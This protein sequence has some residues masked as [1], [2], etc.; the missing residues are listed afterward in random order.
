MVQRWEKN[1]CEIFTSTLPSITSETVN[2]TEYM[3]GKPSV[4]AKLAKQMPLATLMLEGE[5]K[6]A[7]SLQSFYGW[8]AEF[9]CHIC[10]PL[11][12]SP[13]PAV[14][15]ILTLVSVQRVP[16]AIAARR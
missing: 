8:S 10:A 13:E 15:A 12:P 3:Q 4:L 1:I 9:I 16:Q 14:E 7:V 2:C 5:K 11:L 6:N